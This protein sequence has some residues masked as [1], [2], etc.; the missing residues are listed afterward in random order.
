MEKLNRKQKR[1]LFLV[2]LLIALVVVVI[3][4]QNR[5]RPSREALIEPSEQSRVL[6]LL[7]SHGEERRIGVEEQ[8]EVLDSLKQSG[9]RTINESDTENVLE[10]LNRKD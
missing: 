7:G 2:I 3:V 6:E 8:E 1:V 5:Q 10:N 4:F 9:T